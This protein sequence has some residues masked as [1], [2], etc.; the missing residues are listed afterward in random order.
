MKKYEKPEF[1]LIKASSPDVI[2]SS[3]D[4]PTLPE[5]ELDL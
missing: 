3:S 1:D 2:V 4:E 5:E